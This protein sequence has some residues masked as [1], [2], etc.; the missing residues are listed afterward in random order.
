VFGIGQTPFLGLPFPG[1]S[2]PD[3]FSFFFFASSRHRPPLC[4]ERLLCIELPPS[5]RRESLTREPPPFLMVGLSPEFVLEPE[6]RPP[7]RGPPFFPPDQTE[8]LTMFFDARLRVGSFGAPGI[9]WFFPSG[10]RF[11]EI[12]RSE[13]WRSP[14]L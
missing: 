1:R 12:E 7:C 2:P 10:D 5:S 4:E 3:A 9:R 6:D 14:S 11:S 13:G 8:L